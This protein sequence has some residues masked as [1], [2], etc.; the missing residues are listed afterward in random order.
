MSD[1]SIKMMAG[2]N[3]QKTKDQ[4]TI[5]TDARASCMLGARLGRVTRNASVGVALGVASVAAFGTAAQTMAVSYSPK[6]TRVSA[7]FEDVKDVKLRSLPKKDG[8]GSFAAST[9]W[10]E[11]PAVIVVMRRPG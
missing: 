11:N 5:L 6:H 1:A 9:L 3:R 2:I 7:S 10:K 8:E 4:P